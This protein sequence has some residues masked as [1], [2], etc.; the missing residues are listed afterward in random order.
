MVEAAEAAGVEAAAVE[1]AGA[2]AAVA[3]VAAAVC[4]GELAAGARLAHLPLTGTTSYGRV[5]FDPAN[6]LCCSQRCV[7][8][9]ARPDASFGLLI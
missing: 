1:V 6:P 8:T 3:A 9:V 5:S 2:A 4:P 7:E